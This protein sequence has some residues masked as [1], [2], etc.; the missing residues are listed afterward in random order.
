MPGSRL[1]DRDVDVI[2]PRVFNNSDIGITRACVAWL[3][4][5]A[6][7]GGCLV[8]SLDQEPADLRMSKS[9]LFAVEGTVGRVVRVEAEVYPGLRA[10]T[11]NRFP[12]HS[13]AKRGQQIG[14]YGSCVY[15]MGEIGLGTHSGAIRV[16]SN[17]GRYVQTL[18]G[19]GQLKR[20]TGEASKTLCRWTNLTLQGKRR[21]RP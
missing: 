17:D 3:R 2:G 21:T 20:F 4:S 15:S 19:I 11:A 1:D 5:D 12:S 16:D 14:T 9:T 7:I 6:S 13:A 18:R 8:M 10:A